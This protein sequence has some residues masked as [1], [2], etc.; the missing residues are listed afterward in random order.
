[1]EGLKPLDVGERQAMTS[2]R[3]RKTAK[4]RHRRK[5]QGSP[6]L[7]L[8]RFSSSSRTSPEKLPGKSRLRR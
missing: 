7:V 3:A 8:C 2:R 1:M 6:S 5:N 4:D